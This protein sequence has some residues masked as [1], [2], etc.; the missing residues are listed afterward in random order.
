MAVTP[1]HLY[2]LDGVRA[3]VPE[4]VLRAAHRQIV[5][6]ARH[7]SHPVLT[8][9]HLARL[10]GASYSYL[11][12]I[13]SRSVDPYGDIVRPKRTGGRRVLS[14]P[15]PILM[16]VQRWILRNALA[17]LPLDD[18][19]YAY[20]S[21][22]SV[23]QC[24]KQH[25]GARW[26]VKLD[27]HDF[28]GSVTEKHAYGAFRNRGYAP[29]VSQEL[30]RLCTRVAGVA[31]RGSAEDYKRYPVIR[32]YV[33]RDM[34]TL[35]Q[36]APT[37]GALANYAA[38]EMDR[39]LASLADTE[40]M[41]YTRYSDDL[42]FS[43]ALSFGRESAA[44]VVRKAYDAIIGAGFTPH[45]KKTAV[46]PPGAR[47][48]VLGLV[49]EGERLRLTREFKRRVEVH[50]R[51]SAK[52]GVVAHSTDRGFR[53]VISFVEHVSGSLAYAH[54]VEPGWTRQQIVI[55]NRALESSRLE[56]LR[57]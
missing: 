44:R 52:F 53:S 9:M 1:P 13:V 57:I 42:T 30:A 5:E 7:E 23:V 28:F 24:A 15:E 2:L 29:L 34:G 38:S 20:R 49:V 48:I 19:C 35:P 55:W 17:S 39:A 3:G 37:S 40:G 43:T 36:G 31:H 22:R 25:V 4:P 47:R 50:I 12:E 14:S 56:A 51:G 16:D 10:T 54:E 8:L 27:L 45:F 33:V 46:V 26:L 11:R 6:S 18:A 21:G 32:S 41:L